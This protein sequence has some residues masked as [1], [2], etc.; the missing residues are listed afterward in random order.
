M[1]RHS[2]LAFPKP[3]R[4]EDVDYLRFIRRQACLICPAASEAHHTRTRGSGGSDYLT[5]PLCPKH[6]REI[7]KRG[8]AWFEI[9]YRVDL[10]SELI[11]FLEIYLSAL[12]AGE[13]LGAKER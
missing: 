7:H 5:L 11:R 3:A 9:E 8:L 2:V 4:L 1:S 12:K 6:H 13:D 10:R